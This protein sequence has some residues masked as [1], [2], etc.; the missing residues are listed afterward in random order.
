M[1][2]QSHD[3]RLLVL[4]SPFFVMLTAKIEERGP[5]KVAWRFADVDQA[6]RFIEE[7]DKGKIVIDAGVSCEW[8]GV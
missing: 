2:K 1:R 7:A 6:L 5:R 8:V 3:E 4:W